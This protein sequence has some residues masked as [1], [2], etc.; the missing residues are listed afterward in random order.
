MLLLIMLFK[1]VVQDGVDGEFL[2]VMESQKKRCP[3][4]PHL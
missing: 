1:L 2:C 3:D 4:V